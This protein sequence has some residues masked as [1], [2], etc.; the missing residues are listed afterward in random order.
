MLFGPRL[1]EHAPL[2]I[3]LLLRVI[4]SV[5]YLKVLVLFCLELNI[6]EESAKVQWRIRNAERRNKGKGTEFMEEWDWSGSMDLGSQPDRPA[7]HSLECRLGFN[8]WIFMLTDQLH[9]SALIR[10]K[11][12]NRLSFADEQIDFGL[13]A[14]FYAEYIY[15]NTLSSSV[16]VT[17]TWDSTNGS[18]SSSRRRNGTGCLF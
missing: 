11:S 2:L 14:S 16:T 8:Q 3:L 9:W 15:W 12:F 17:L 4:G 6:E 10:L 18:N 1:Q 13:F 7:E 5:D